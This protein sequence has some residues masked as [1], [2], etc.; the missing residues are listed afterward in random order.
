MFSTRAADKL[1]QWHLEFFPARKPG[2]VDSIPGPVDIA[3]PDALEAKQNITV[4]LRSDLLQLISKTDYARRPHVLYRS[5]WPL[6]LGPFIRGHKL[7]VVAGLYD[8]SGKSFQIRLSAT[9]RRITAA[10]ESD[11]EF[12][13]CRILVHLLGSIPL[14]GRFCETPTRR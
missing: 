10:N 12:L 3:T 2:A 6:V 4:E 5:K 1:L 13:H 7:D 8:S 14:V 11:S 9:A